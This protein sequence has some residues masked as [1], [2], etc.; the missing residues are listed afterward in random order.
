M[1]GG[2]V[3][4]ANDAIAELL[5]RAAAEEQGHR[6]RALDRAAKAAWTWPEEAAE[7]ARSGR[8]LTDLHG[9]GPWIA[10]RIDAWLHDPPADPE[11]DETRSGYITYAHVRRVLDAEPLWEATSHGDLQVHSTASDGAL[12]IE[13]MASAARTVGR[14]YLAS[15]D[16]SSSLTVAH[17]M[18]HDELLAHVAEIDACNARAAADG[19]P[20]RILRSIEMDVFV[21]G[22]GDMDP[23]DLGRLDLVL[24]AFHSKLRERSDAT[25]RY[26]AALRNPTVHVLAHPT[27]RMFG[28]RRGLVA[29]W[30]R[31]FAEAAR[32]GKAVEIDATPRRQDLPVE[33]ASIALAEGVAWFSI[34]SDAHDAGELTHLPIGMAIAVLAGIPRDRIL[35]YLPAD[36]VVGWARRVGS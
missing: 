16:H 23:S 33:L 35:N 18:S 21:D 34:G 15:T 9:V 6:E 25:E 11:P 13:E 19:D 30:H 14:A 20:F 28:R 4:P 32:L 24:G 10:E 8:A 29:D 31:V 26:V 2:P 27:T 7:V 17:G 5:L 36:E 22:S 12:P 3:P 1:A